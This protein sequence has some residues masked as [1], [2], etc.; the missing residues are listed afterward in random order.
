MKSFLKALA[1]ATALSTIGVVAAGQANADW[2]M[3]EQIEKT[4]VIVGG[5]CSG[6][7]IDKEERLVLTAYHCVADQYYEEEVTEVDDKTGE[8]KTKKV[9]K[10]RPLAVSARKMTDF[11][12]VSVT[13]HLVKIVGSDNKN[14]IALLQVV[15]RDFVPAMEA[16][17]APDSFQYKRG[18]P[19]FAIGNP[20]IAFDNSITQGIISAPQRPIVFGGTTYHFFQ[21]SANVIGGNSGG[22]VVNE[23]GEIVGTI[24]ASL[25]GADISFAVPISYTKEM[26]KKAGFIGVLPPKAKTYFED[27]ADRYPETKRK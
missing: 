8:I 3:D 27:V 7:I 12:V 18:T 9:Q 16:K 21:H 24:S 22:C 19:V 23:D 10:K 11:E 25:R 13:E 6:T 1:L 17:L 4:N 20:G 15:D 26:I 14:D 5:V 2:S